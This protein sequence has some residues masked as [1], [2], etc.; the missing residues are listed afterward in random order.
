MKVFESAKQVVIFVAAAVA[1]LGALGGLY[2][3]VMESVDRRVDSVLRDAETI[4]ALAAKVRRPSL[5]F[6]SRNRVLDDQGAMAYLSK[7]PRFINAA[8]DRPPEIVVAPKIH[9]ASPPLLQVLDTYYCD[10]EAERGEGLTWIFRGHW[11][12]GGGFIEEAQSSNPRFRL[13]I[14]R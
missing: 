5:V 14:V 2:I 7:A 6:D 9:L 12:P 8:E 4:E 13:E 11:Q 3:L 1:F 10:F